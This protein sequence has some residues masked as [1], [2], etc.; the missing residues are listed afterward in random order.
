MPGDKTRLFHHGVIAT[1]ALCALLQLHQTRCDLEYTVL[2]TTMVP[3]AD[4]FLLRV[5]AGPSYDPSTHVIVPVNGPTSIPIS[6][7]QCTANLKVRVQNY[8]GELRDNVPS[9][10]AL[11][12]TNYSSQAFPTAPRPPPLTSP[13][14]PIPMTS[15]PL[16]SASFRPRL[17]RAMISCSAMTS[18]APSRTVFLPALIPP[19]RS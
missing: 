6:S 11:H 13:P 19:S 4:H 8:R 5:T 9:S 1:R 14:H 7:K 15:T 12:G 10:K 16:P 17:S 2:H 18:T 3:S